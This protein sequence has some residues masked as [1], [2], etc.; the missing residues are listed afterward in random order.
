MSSKKINGAYLKSTFRDIFRSPGR[1][2]SIIII[3]MMG[4][5]LFVGIKAV[6]PNL[7]NTMD[8]YYK[9]YN[10]SDIQV[11]ALQGFSDNDKNA[12]KNLN[13]AKVEFGHSIPFADENAGNTIQLISYDAEG[14]HNRLHVV[15]GRAP[16]AENEIAVDRRLQEDYPLNSFIS[17]ETPALKEDKFKVVGFVNSPTFIA[18]SERGPSAIGG[19]R[20]DGF[21]AV[22][23]DAFVSPI[24][25][26]ATISFSSLADRKNSSQ[27]Y[28][29][30]VKEKT[31]KIENVIDTDNFII[32]NR[33]SDPGYSDYDGLSSRIDLIG[34]VFPVFFFFIAGLITFTTMVRFVEENRQEIGTLKSLGYK[35]REIFR[36]YVIFSMFVAIVG[37][38]GGILIGTYLLPLAV[39]F[40]LQN[41][42][43]FTD[44]TTSFYLWPI[45]ISVVAT[46]V[47]TL[48]ASIISLWGTLK[49]KPTSLLAM[50]APKMGKAVFLERF[51]FLWSRLSF[52]QKITYRNIARYKSRMILT[53]LG[54]AGCTGLMLAGFGLRDSI[55]GTASLE[56]TNVIKYQ[57]IVSLNKDIDNSGRE[58][59][60]K[61]LDNKAG[62]SSKGVFMNQLTVEKDDI[63]AQNVTF[64][65]TNNVKDFSSFFNAQTVDGDKISPTNDGVVVG[66]KLA[67]LY[68][69]N[70]GDKISAQDING[71]KYDFKVAGIMNNYMG[72]Y[73][74]ATI[75]YAQEIMEKTLT[76]NAF[77]VKIKNTSST[78]EKK[79]SEDLIAT[80]NVSA[81]TMTSS[82]IEKQDRM[83]QSFSPVVLIFIILS[84]ILAFVVLYN[85]TAINILERQREL[86]TLR[87]LGFYNSEVTMYIVRENVIFTTIGI[88]LG[89]LIGNVLTWF[90]LEVA[91][92]DQLAFPFII[93]WQGYL[94]A[95]LGTVLF[96]AIV[97]VAT[98]IKLRNVD[99]IKALKSSD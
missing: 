37:L 79:L 94:I 59:V 33:T 35:N 52:N 89:Y 1:M 76:Q 63:S 73:M 20:M 5:L 16:T 83:T 91:S 53:V 34:N 54:I 99:M 26:T 69:M 38:I 74:V 75:D 42:Y 88:L 22:P 48:G 50:K 40:M 51:P 44:Y 56:T 81:V 95:T 28:K 3:I 66:R 46:I 14:Q 30:A 23:V 70:V 9:K 31:K 11:T 13:G 71:K 98:H 86:S 58:E 72:H 60:Q 97:S 96:T 67:N 93:H 62:V 47:V 24:Y 36:K 80:G 25:S 68:D 15:E 57:A 41:Q 90:I 64:F 84:G 21:F 12:L 17:I 19:G 61:I 65:A 49:E 85:L 92:S 27:E 6:G 29:D 45:V 39:F 87:V 8:A 43:I 4:V 32:S 78:V 18:D 2:L 82:Q 7:E 10:L 77:L 55:G